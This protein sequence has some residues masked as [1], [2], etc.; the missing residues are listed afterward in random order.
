MSSWILG[1]LCMSAVAQGNDYSSFNL[2]AVGPD[3]ENYTKVFLLTFSLSVVF[4][5]SFC[6]TQT[7]TLSLSLFS[8]SLSQTLSPPFDD[9]LSRCANIVRV[10]LA[11]TELTPRTR[12]V[13][14]NIN[15]SR[16]R[17]YQAGTKTTRARNCM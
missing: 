7:H 4:F 15:M 11:T 2:L 13:R 16:Y 5:F 12:F 10:T 17:T 9:E 3:T 8:L 6:P 14:E 1:I